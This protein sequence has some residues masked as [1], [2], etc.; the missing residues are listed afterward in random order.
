MRVLWAVDLWCLFLQQFAAFYAR[1]CESRTWYPV[2]YSTQTSTNAAE[3]AAKRCPKGSFG[4]VLGFVTRCSH[5]MTMRRASFRAQNAATTRWP[6]RTKLNHQRSTAPS[7]PAMT[8]TAVS[9]VERGMVS[10]PLRRVELPSAALLT[11]HACQRTDKL[12]HKRFTLCIERCAGDQSIQH[13]FAVWLAPHLLAKT[14][15]QF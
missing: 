10:A 8:N 9:T 4:D 3:R 14:K 13:Q 6:K 2:C 11:R 12:R 1:Q 7:S 15:A 5:R